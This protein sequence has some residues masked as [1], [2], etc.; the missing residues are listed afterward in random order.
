MTIKL[1]VWTPVGSQLQ[2]GG[3]VFTFQ[4]LP[5]SGPAPSCTNME[6]EPIFKLNRETPG[7]AGHKNHSWVVCKPMSDFALPANGFI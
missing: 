7:G 6:P 2:C 4:P 5:I 1:R 3:R